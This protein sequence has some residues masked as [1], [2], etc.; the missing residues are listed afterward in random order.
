M[1]Q[2]AN[3]LIFNA[4]P[5]FYISNALS[6]IAFN[7]W[8]T[9]SYLSMAHI[10]WAEC[11]IVV[12]FSSK[13]IKS[14]FH[15]SNRFFFVNSI[16]FVFTATRDPFGIKELEFGECEVSPKLNSFH[17]KYNQI[18]IKNF[19]K[20]NNFRLKIFVLRKEWRKKNTLF[21]WYLHG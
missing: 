20:L 12:A 19:S 13:W 3:M 5:K 10:L 18:F 6:T 11:L 14:A 9:Y 1:E 8:L 16:Q 2:I 4:I 17:H 21:W 7:L 15:I